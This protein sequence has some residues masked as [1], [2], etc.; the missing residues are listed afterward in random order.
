VL[1]VKPGGDGRLLPRILR[2]PDGVT[3]LPV[4]D[5]PETTV[6]IAWAKDSRSLHVA[7]FVR[8]AAEVAAR[9]R[10]AG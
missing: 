9:Q 1:A 3:C 10:V 6:V 2:V 7:A 5:A 8:V 4:T